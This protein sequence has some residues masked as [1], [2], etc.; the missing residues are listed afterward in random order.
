MGGKKQGR[1]PETQFPVLPVLC[2]GVLASAC[3]RQIL[4]HSFCVV[5]QPAIP[6]I[7]AQKEKKKNILAVGPDSLNAQCSI[8]RA[9][10]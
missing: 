3:A 10:C 2:G 6:A 9:S 1:L 4:I 5:N 7:A 8:S